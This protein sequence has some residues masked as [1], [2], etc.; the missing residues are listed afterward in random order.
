MTDQVFVHESAV[1]ES[2]A[3][4]G[5]GAKVW[6]FCHV[7]SGARLGARVMLGQGCFVASGV[8]IGEGSRI[9]NQVSLYDGVVIEEDVFVGPSAVFTNMRSP[10]AFVSQTGSYQR[11][12]IRRGATIGAN[13]TVI[14][15][16]TLG[17]YC[18]VGAGAVV[19][20]DVGDFVLV[21]GVPARPAGFVSRRGVRLVFSQGRA[22]CPEAGEEYL[23]IDGRLVE[24]PE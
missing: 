13:A 11:T 5:P 22:R 9:Q 8:S 19:T 14:A 4:L 16:V 3:E 6:H 15:G 17:R 2:G 20:H 10:R 24:A 18:L 1:V 23:L 21:A 7:M 12:L